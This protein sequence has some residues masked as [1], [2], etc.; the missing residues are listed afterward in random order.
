[1]RGSNIITSLIRGYLMETRSW[2]LRSVNIVSGKFT[3]A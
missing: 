3:V 2:R 1:M